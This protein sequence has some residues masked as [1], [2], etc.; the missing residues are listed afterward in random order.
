[1]KR[2]DKNTQKRVLTDLAI[3][4]KTKQSIA[5]SNNI[6]VNT[7][8]NILHRNPELYQN[9]VEKLK[10]QLTGYALLKA[11]KV[12]RRVKNDKINE[13]SLSSLAGSYKMLIDTTKN[14]DNSINFTVNIPKTNDELINYVM[15]TTSIDLPVDNFSKKEDK[16]DTEKDIDKSI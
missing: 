14:N 9:L 3:G 7:V 6:H 4:C 15:D 13:A 2:I 12:L 8:D 16:T 5:K 10:N 1:M 11:K